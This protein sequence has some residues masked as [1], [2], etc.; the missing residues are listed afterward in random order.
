MTLSEKIARFVASPPPFT[1]KAVNL[2]VRSMIDTM[3]AMVI[4]SDTSAVKMAE[5]M[6]PL[7]G[8]CTVIGNGRK[9]PAR[10][11]AFINGISGHELELDDTSSSNLGHPTAAVLPSLLAAGEDR[12]CSGRKLIEAFL[13]ATEAECKIGR[14]CARKLHEKGWHASSVTGVIGAAAGSAYILGLNEERTRNAIG[15]AASMASGVRENFGTLTKSI[16]IGKTAEDGLRAALLAEGGFTSSKAALEGKEGYIFEYA[17]IRDEERKFDA[18]IDS[19]G[20]DWDICSPGFTLKRYPSCSS[21]HRPVD[22]L[23]DIINENDIKA[24]EVERID[25]GLSEAALRELVAPYPKDGEEAKFSVGFQTAL[26]LHGMENMPYNYTEEV[27][28]EDKILNIIQRTF[29]HEET[30]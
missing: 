16:H 19:M 25:I 18:I 27:I 7:E 20:H 24:D 8:N 21:T 5:K 14:I 26:Y 9:V 10:D 3:G 17:G 30:K 22:A 13:I 2:A 11:A 28:R 23:I 6:A 12:G 15:I 29:M 4:G 1:E